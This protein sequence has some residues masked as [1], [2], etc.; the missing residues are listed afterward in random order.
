M[1]IGS[2]GTITPPARGQLLPEG[3]S[4]SSC[5]SRR[6][7]TGRG[8]RKVSPSLKCTSRPRHLFNHRPH[9]TRIYFDHTTIEFVPSSRIVPV[10]AHA[11]FD[12]AAAYFKIKIHKIPV[13]AVTRKVNL[14]HV[15]RAMY[16]P[17]VS[18]A[19]LFSLISLHVHKLTSPPFLPHLQT[20]L[21]DRNPNTIMVRPLF[22]LVFSLP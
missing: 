9:L 17:F 19:S 2:A 21:F 16:A 15:R 8:H 10:T 5:L 13:D 6:I 7:E 4:L 12:K 18:I 20:C 14:K 11:A 1:T 3:Q 22:H